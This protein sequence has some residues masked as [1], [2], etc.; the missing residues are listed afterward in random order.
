MVP[1]VNRWRTAVFT[2]C[3]F[4]GVGSIYYMYSEQIL[5][6]WA[7]IFGGWILCIFVASGGEVYHR[8]L[9]KAEAARKKELLGEKHQA[10]LARTALLK[11]LAIEDN[12][13]LKGNADFG[14]SGGFWYWGGGTEMEMVESGAA[15]FGSEAGFYYWGPKDFVKHEMED[16]EMDSKT[17]RGRKKKDSKKKGVRAKPELK[18]KPSLKKKTSFK[19]DLSKLSDEEFEAEMKRQ[20]KEKRERK[21][22]AVQKKLQKELS[23]R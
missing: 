14:A 12:K 19:V 16:D 4:S 17:K 6:S 23:P 1:E 2:A 15:S 10:M 22:A 5:Y 20:A 21:K 9:K 11:R 18:K 8:K 13:I 3:A 7:I